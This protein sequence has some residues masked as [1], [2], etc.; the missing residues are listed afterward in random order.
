MCDSTSNATGLHFTPCLNLPAILTQVYSRPMKNSSPLFPPE[1]TAA[2]LANLAWCALIALRLAQQEGQALSALTL[3]TFLL[4]WLAVAQKQRRFPRSVAPDIESLLR[5]GRQKGPS[6]ELHQRLEYLWHSWSTPLTQQ[7]DLFR[8]TQAI[9]QLKS[10]G[11]INAVV[12]D[13]EWEL[14]RLQAEY[15][16]AAAFLVKKSMLVRQFSEDGR[17]LGPLDFLVVG[18]CGAVGEAL[19][20]GGLH[21]V[22]KEQHDGGGR[23]ILM[24]LSETFTDANITDAQRA[25]H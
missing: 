14:Q 2:D 17:L 24:P 11:W 18:D 10:Q 7:S 16:D 6:A 22:T 19:S 4:R 1:Q 25:A 15:A 8:L 3:H 13:D 9:E 23:V 21:Y 12:A 20:N 5:L